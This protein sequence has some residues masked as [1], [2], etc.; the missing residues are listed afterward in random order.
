[1]R[2]PRLWMGAAA[3]ALGAGVWLGVHLAHGHPSAS[4]QTA[5]SPAPAPDPVVGPDTIFRYRTFYA[6][7]GVER[8]GSAPAPLALVGLD[9]AGVERALPQ[10][11]ILSFGPDEVVLLETVQGCP[12]R[13]VTL[14]IRDGVVVAYYGRPG[15]LG[16]VYRVTGIRASSLTPADRARLERGVVFEDPAEV[17]R[18]IE[19]LGD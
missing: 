15:H 19:G 5:P 6:G 10:A 4:G 17:D 3:L 16:G 1:L 18:Q 9:R 8:E 14:T 12:F 2:V 13:Y 11:R 7:C